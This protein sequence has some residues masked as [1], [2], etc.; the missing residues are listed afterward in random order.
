M[1]IGYEKGEICN[2]NGCNGILVE[3]DTDK[4]CSCHISA[5]CSYC[6][7]SRVYCL[8]CDW[9][10]R[11]EQIEEDKKTSRSIKKEYEVF[12]PRT[13]GDL[14]RTKI[15]YICSTHTHF[16]M[17]KKGV[18]PKGTKRYEVEKIVKG[19]FGGRFKYF[20]DITCEFEYVAYTD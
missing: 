20:S 16:S 7:D 10:G 13:M 8:K 19:T 14:D 3:R 4:C 5:P 11:E 12:K 2:R 9:D 17:I 1:D 15:D 18:F 6:T